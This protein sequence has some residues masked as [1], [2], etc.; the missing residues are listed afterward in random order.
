M[1]LLQNKCILFKSIHLSAEYL[2]NCQF[3]IP[4]SYNLNLISHDTAISLLQFYISER[5]E[6]KIKTVY[7]DTV[8]PKEKY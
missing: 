3:Q 4:V 5:K 7:V 8:G 6:I 2:S 1:L